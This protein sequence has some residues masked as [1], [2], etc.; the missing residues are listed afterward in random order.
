LAGVDVGEDLAAAGRILG[1]F[2]Q[3][4][5]LRLLRERDKSRLVSACLNE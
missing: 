3:D 4:D 1:T 5:D 2:L